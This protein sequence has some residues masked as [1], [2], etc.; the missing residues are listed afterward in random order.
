MRQLGPPWLGDVIWR[1][2]QR[3]RPGVRA[4]GIQAFGERDQAAL[5]LMALKFSRVWE[6]NQGSMETPSVAQ[7]KDQPLILILKRANHLQ[8]H[9]DPTFGL[10]DRRNCWLICYLG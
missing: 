6:G 7:G 4:R 2:Q 3:G 9:F 8:S 5:G 10:Q 1:Y